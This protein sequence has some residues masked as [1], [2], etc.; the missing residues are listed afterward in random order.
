MP[1]L[2]WKRTSAVKGALT[3]LKVGLAF[4]PGGREVLMFWIDERPLSRAQTK[5][6]LF[7]L[8]ERKVENFAR[9]TVRHGEN[10]KC[11]TKKFLKSFPPGSNSVEATKKSVQN[12]GESTK[13]HIGQ[14]MIIRTIFLRRLRSL[15]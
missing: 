1:G 7:E 6:E 5:L 13:S 2:L 8:C 4:M 15:R 11:L 14:F 3:T 10:A 9:Q 12:T